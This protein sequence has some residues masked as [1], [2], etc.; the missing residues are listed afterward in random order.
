VTAEGRLPLDPVTGIELSGFTENIWLG[1]SMLH[2]LFAL[3]HN[4]ICDMLK[5]HYPAWNDEQLYEKARLINSALLAKIHTVEWTPAILPHP[6]HQT[7]DEGRT[8]ME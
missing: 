8:G 1:L 7:G 2:T 5:G 3:E 4:A 6:D